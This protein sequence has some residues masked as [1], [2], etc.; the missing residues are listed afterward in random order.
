MEEA[1]DR[2]GTETAVDSQKPAAV[3]G[4]SGKSSG[5]GGR[6]VA[7]GVGSAGEHVVAQRDALVADR[8]PLARDDL[9]AVFHFGAAQP[10]VIRTP[11]GAWIATAPC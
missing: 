7:G 9:L 2:T 5:K 8:R 4:V 11:R 3:S 1:T 10:A 6:L